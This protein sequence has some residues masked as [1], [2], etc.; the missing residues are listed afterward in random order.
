MYSR[1]YWSTNTS[2]TFKTT[3]EHV[4]LTASAILHPTYFL[5]L[6]NFTPCEQGISAAK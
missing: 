6:G 4:I 3:L 1:A 2:V 5:M